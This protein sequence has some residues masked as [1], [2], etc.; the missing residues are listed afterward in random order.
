M[1]A[2]SEC[3]RLPIHRQVITELGWLLCGPNAILGGKGSIVH[4][5]TMTSTKNVVTTVRAQLPL[6]L[7]KECLSRYD[8]LVL[9]FSQKRSSSVHWLL[10]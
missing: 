1:S 3:K 8:M 6:L 2:L 5:S 10:Q 9:F 7:P 4:D